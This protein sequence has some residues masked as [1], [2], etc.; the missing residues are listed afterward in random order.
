MAGWLG[1][2]LTRPRETFQLDGHIP[3]VGIQRGQVAQDPFRPGELFPA[4]V[5]DR[6]IVEPSFHVVALALLAQDGKL[7]VQ[8]LIR[9]ALPAIV[10]GCGNLDRS[11]FRPGGRVATEQHQA[12]GEKGEGRRG[13]QLRPYARTDD[14]P[15]FG[16]QADDRQR[17]SRGHGGAH[18]HGAHPDDHGSADNQQQRQLDA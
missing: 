1:G 15:G 4:A 5:A 2:L 8:I 17:R 6:D 9:L 13:H 7:Q 3:V 18:G 11:G 16:D 10:F 14:Q 12:A